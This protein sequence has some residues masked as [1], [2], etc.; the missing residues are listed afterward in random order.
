MK[1]LLRLTLLLLAFLSATV[2]FAQVGLT[3]SGGTGT[4]TFTTL[5]AAFDAINLGTHQGNIVITITGTSTETLTAT[6]NAS[7]SGGASYSAIL[8]K[9]SGAAFITGSISGHLIDLNSANN[10]TIDGLNTSGNSL[11]ISNAGIASASTIR[12]ANDAS[13]NVV[14]RCTLLGSTT[15]FGVV[16]F[17]PGTTTGNDNNTVSYCNIG[18]AGANNPQNGIY[19]A[20]TSVLIDNSGNTISNNNIYDYFNTTNAS[21]G[22]N[23]N[24]YNSA[25]TITTNRLYQTAN[26]VYTSAGS[27]YGIFI[28]SGAGYTITGNVIGYA[29]SAGTGTTNMIGL[30]SGALT[31]TF[32]SAYGVGGVAIAAKYAAINCAFTTGGTVSSIQNNTIAG[33]ALYT[34]SNTSGTFGVFCGI[35][36][37]SG[38]ANIG[39]VTG[40]NIGTPTSSIYIATA[41]SGGAI[42]GI[43]TTSSNTV[44]IQNNVLQNL[45]AMGTSATTAGSINGINTEGAG[46]TVIVSGNT[47]GG[48]ATPSLRLGNLTTGPNLS[49]V[50]TTFGTASGTSLFQG[51]RN[52]QTGTVTIGTQTAPNIVRNATI[53]STGSLALYRGIYVAGG[54]TSVT[55]NT[56]SNLSSVSTGASYSSAGLAGIGILM[57]SA[58]NGVIA[59][60]TINGLS[61]TNTAASGY[62][63]GGIVYNTPVTS[64]TVSKNK[65]YGLSNAGTGTSVT[66]PPTATGI[67]IRD[68][69][70]AATSIDNNMISLGNGEATNTAFFGIWAQYNTAA[71]TT[72]KIYH[73]SVNIEGA[74]TSGA[75]PSFCF[76]RGDLSTTAAGVYTVDAK[77]NIFSNTRSGGTG[78]HYAISNNYGAVT[79]NATGWGANASDYNVLNGNAATIGFW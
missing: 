54:T 38:N 15:S 59:N 56:I 31:G 58:I 12:F 45:D 30:S 71:A 35:A 6:L 1:N 67:F 8:I 10:V 40:N 22:M 42:A 64:I 23:I 21:S 26:R 52:A 79:S 73:N 53:N 3:A 13:N 43:Y 62:T 68:G 69:S 9:P 77:N 41:N 63:L 66:A 72:L 16:Y 55:Y 65:I 27:H 47:I 18:A 76:Q 4:G 39:T 20:G 49:N 28:T 57:I 74:A 29:N 37:T 78:K 70:G 34:N 33:F 7:G 75:Q 61:L 46:G 48:T 50:G 51:I 11:T 60:N 36:V 25:W 2:S 14:T 32:P 24:S 19:S 5:K 17:G 44:T